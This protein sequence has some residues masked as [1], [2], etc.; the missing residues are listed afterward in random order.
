M[1]T[2]EYDN[3][4][5]P[6]S[7]FKGDSYV[8]RKLNGEYM[9]YQWLLNNKDGIPMMGLNITEYLPH[10][11]YQEYARAGWDWLKHFSRDPETHEISYDPYAK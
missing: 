2:L 5:Y 7:G 8:E 11:L 10:G 6:L 1:D 3:D 9:N 4:T